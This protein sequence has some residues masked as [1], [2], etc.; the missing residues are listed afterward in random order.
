MTQND[1][2]F[3][4]KSLYLVHTK[5]LLKTASYYWQHNALFLPNYGRSEFHV[6][7]N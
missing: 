7:E 6:T 3:E 5:T 1:N 2:K 4:E